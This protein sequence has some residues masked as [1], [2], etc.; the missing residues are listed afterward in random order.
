MSWTFLIPLVVGMAGILQGGVYSK[1]SKEIG[2]TQGLLIGN[3]LVLLI[4]LV[5]VF[6]VSK[7]PSAFP[8][9]FRLKAP[10]SAFKWWYLLP[11]IFGFI[12][13]TGLPAGMVNLGAIKTTVLILVAQMITSIV[14][15]VSVEKLPIN[16]M[17]SL[18]LIFSIIAVACTLYS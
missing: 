17:K 11:G 5:L 8:E 15:D 14:W 7:Y 18:G 10:L 13:I 1:L 9:F 16:T 12:I 3:A 6:A 4:S 2:L